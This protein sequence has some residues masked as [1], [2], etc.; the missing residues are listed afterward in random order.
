MI[1]NFCGT[2][3]YIE[4]WNRYHRMHSACLLT[5]AGRR[6][7]LDAG[8]NWAGKLAELWPDWIAITH[9]HPDHAFGLRDGVGVPVLGTRKTHRLL[10]GFPIS[11]FHEIKPGTMTRCGPFQITAYRVIHSLRA[12]AVGFRITAGGLT[13][14]YNPDIISPVRPRAA[15]SGVDVYIGDGSS[16]TRPLVRRH[17]TLLFGHTTVRA[18][19]GWCRRFSIRRAFFVH[20]GKQ[21]VEMD[22]RELDRAVAEL[23]GGNPITVVARDG[24]RVDLASLR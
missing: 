21:L 23:A 17:G 6:L 18:Q 15:L 16:L 7:L 11:R 10:R 9:A 20:C 14:A 4:E 3:G 1:V 13:I 2:R 8:E 19:L 22:A 5:H 12:P 24:M